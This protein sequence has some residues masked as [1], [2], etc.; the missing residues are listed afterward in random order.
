MKK[1]DARKLLSTEGKPRNREEVAVALEKATQEVAAY[2]EKNF[3]AQFV[4]TCTHAAEH[5]GHIVG[6]YRSLGQVRPASRKDYK[7]VAFERVMAP[8][9]PVR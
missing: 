9:P 2:M 3:D 5:Y 7:G 8:V 1:V 6:I 4:S